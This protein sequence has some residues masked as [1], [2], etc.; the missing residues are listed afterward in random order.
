MNK[1][2]I[3]ALIALAFAAIGAFQPIVEVD[4]TKVTL[5]TTPAW[6]LILWAGVAVVL[7]LYGRKKREYVGPA[8][9][10]ALNPVFTKTVLENMTI[11]EMHVGE[12]KVAFGYGAYMAWAASL[13]IFGVV[14]GK[15]PE[16]P[17]DEPAK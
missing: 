3:N 2:P 10:L 1:P 12:V 14:F 8:L 16:V 17:A 5:S 4:S 9:L 11:P 7:G 15:D 13:M 6:G